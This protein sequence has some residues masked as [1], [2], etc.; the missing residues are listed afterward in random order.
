[1]KDILK[2]L[3]I[4]KLDESQQE[5]LKEKLESIVDVKSRER[6]ET[7]LEE[8]KEELV[9]EYEEKFESYKKGITSKFSNFVDSVID[10]ELHIPE[11]VME[12][13]RKGELYDGLIEQFKIKLSLDEGILDSEIKDLLKESKSEILNLRGKVNELTKDNMEFAEDTKKMA[14]HIYLRS[15]CDGLTEVNRQKVLNILGD[16][17]SKEEI[18]KKYDYVVESVLSEKKNNNDDE[19]EDKDKKK[20]KE[21]EEGE[22]FSYECPECGHKF[23]LDEKKDKVKCPECGNV[24][25]VGE[26]EGK[27]ETEVKGEDKKKNENDNPFEKLQERWAKILNE[28]KF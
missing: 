18:D 16:L 4:E 13:A 20:E 7:I 9:T 21:N 28:G 12:F 8:K 14:S 22:S 26:K 17:E 3:G 11:K 15:K 1:M 24:F 6:A 23:E 5:S 19:D 2:I 27:G 25:E 10:E